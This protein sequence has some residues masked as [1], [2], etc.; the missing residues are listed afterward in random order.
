MKR[1]NKLSEYWLASIATAVGM[2]LSLSAPTF[3]QQIPENQIFRIS[4]LPS[5]V[6]QSLVAHTLRIDREQTVTLQQAANTAQQPLTGTPGFD[7]INMMNPA[8]AQNAAYLVVLDN[9]QAVNVPLGVVIRARDHYIV[10]YIPN[11]NTTNAAANTFYRYRDN[12]TNAIVNVPMFARGTPITLNLGLQY[13]QNRNITLD[14]YAI[15][16]AIGAFTTN[17]L[18]ATDNDSVALAALLSESVRFNP[19]RETLIGIMENP[20]VAQNW[21][22]FY[23]RYFRRW[24]ARSNE[25]ITLDTQ[26]NVNVDLE[27]RSRLISLLLELGVV[28]VPKSWRR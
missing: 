6:R 2:L 27:S 4:L 13:P 24:E 14:F 16:R 15:Q 10:G 28:K 21:G 12:S 7:D 17:T 19:W 1:F 5:Q 11:V 20:G 18:Q 3:A 8:I 9:E 26:P 25:L 23:E 22:T